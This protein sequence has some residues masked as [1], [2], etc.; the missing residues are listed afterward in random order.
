L[1]FA[2]KANTGLVQVLQQ[3]DAARVS[4]H[5]QNPDFGICLPNLPGKGETIAVQQVKIDYRD[6]KTERLR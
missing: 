1:E 5:G 4:A 2:V 3:F 6:V